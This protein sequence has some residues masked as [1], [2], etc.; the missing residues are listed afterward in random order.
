MK[1]LTTKGL[2]KIVSLSHNQKKLE[3]AY[4][5][6]PGSIKSKGILATYFLERKTAEYRALKREFENISLSLE[7]LE[8][9]GAGIAVSVSMRM[10]IVMPSAMKEAAPKVQ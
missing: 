9:G 7:A 1:A 3:Y 10:S 6:T 5:L 2:V 8:E 4:L